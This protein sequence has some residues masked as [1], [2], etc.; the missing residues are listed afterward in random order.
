[1][2]G[3]VTMLVVPRHLWY[4]NTNVIVEDGDI[5]ANILLAPAGSEWS[6]EDAK[7]K[8]ITDY[9]AQH[10]RPPSGAAAPADEKA[11]EK[12]EA[13]DKS[14]AGPEE[15]KA[16]ES[17]ETGVSYAAETRRTRRG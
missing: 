9:L 3:G 4:S 14:M 1:M 15:A 6:D 7:A 13:E 11:V 5:N 17:S 16:E 8:G 2:E 12:S 10:P